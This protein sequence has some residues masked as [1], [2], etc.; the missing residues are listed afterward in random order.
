M[1]DKEKLEEIKVKCNAGKLG[2]FIDSKL[3]NP[4]DLKYL[5]ERVQ[6]LEDEIENLE[7]DLWHANHF[8]NLANQKNAIYRIAFKQIKLQILF[9]GAIEDQREN[10]IEI[11]DKALEGESDATRALEVKQENPGQGWF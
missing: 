4:H 5:I 1:T 8:K 11:I 9:D 2:E 6:Q 7:T 3:V 10:I